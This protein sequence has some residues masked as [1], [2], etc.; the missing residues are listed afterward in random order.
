MARVFGP[1]MSI[2]AAGSVGNELTASHWKDRQYIKKWFKPS[3]PNTTA[4]AAQRTEMTNAV[5]AWQG[6]YQSE[7]D[8]WNAAARG[9]YPPISGVNYFVKEYIAQAGAPTIPAIAPKRNLTL[10][11]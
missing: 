9:V 6:L 3:N 11:T 8:N 1:F 2:D 4:Q 7:V 5:A 10:Q